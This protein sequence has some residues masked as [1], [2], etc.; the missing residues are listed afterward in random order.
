MATAE[1]KILPGERM[2]TDALCAAGLERWRGDTAQDIHPMRHG[3]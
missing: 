1:S 3:N 2:A